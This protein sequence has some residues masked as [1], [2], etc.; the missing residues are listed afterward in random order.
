MNNYLPSY[1]PS[2][3]IITYIGIFQYAIIFGSPWTTQKFHGMSQGIFRWK[4]SRPWLWVP[5]AG[6]KRHLGHMGDGPW[7]WL[8][9]TY[10]EPKWPIFEGKPLKTKVFQPKQG[11]F[12]FQVYRGVLCVGLDSMVPPPEI[13]K[14]DD[15]ID[16]PTD[17]FLQQE[18][19]RTV[20]YWKDMKKQ[21]S[22]T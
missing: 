7:G 5:V 14:T 16:I 6:A 19:K 15:E 1:K 9:R 3:L 22:H 13:R 21:D 18:L 8:K 10:L 17:C 11:S 2:F 20:T 4:T 12:G